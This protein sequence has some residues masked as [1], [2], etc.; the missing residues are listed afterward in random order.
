MPQLYLCK[1]EASIMVLCLLH[2]FTPLHSSTN[3]ELLE[4]HVCIK[5]TT[6]KSVDAPVIIWNWSIY[7]ASLSVTYVQLNTRQY[8][9]RTVRKVPL[10]QG[11]YY[12][13]YGRI[14]LC[15]VSHHVQPPN[16][17]FSLSAKMN[18]TQWRTLARK[19]LKNT[20]DI[21]QY[22]K[23]HLSGKKNIEQWKNQTVAMASIKLC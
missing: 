7:F 17:R 22:A 4:K 13:K 18:G 1:N 14:L 12:E 8:K 3:Q 16:Q 20:L 5:V 15:K 2:M 11:C 23:T 9:S 21:L 10:Y 6:M 19:S